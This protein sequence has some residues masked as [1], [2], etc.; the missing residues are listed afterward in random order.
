LLGY[1]LN[2]F[3][4]ILRKMEFKFNSTLQNWLT[5]WGLYVLIYYDLVLWVL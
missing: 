4:I 3:D 5:R 2:E 1:A